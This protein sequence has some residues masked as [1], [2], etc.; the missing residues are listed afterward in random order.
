MAITFYTVT[1]I[2]KLRQHSHHISSYF[3]SSLFLFYLYLV[4]T[5]SFPFFQPLYILSSSFTTCNLIFIYESNKFSKPAKSFIYP[6]AHPAVSST[7]DRSSSSIIASPGRCPVCA[8]TRHCR[9]GLPAVSTSS[10]T[11]L[12]GVTR[13]VSPC[14]IR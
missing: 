12:V 7:N 6:A 14:R 8:T 9:Q 3:K 2:A 10:F 1:A 4:R 13:S 11:Y 5:F